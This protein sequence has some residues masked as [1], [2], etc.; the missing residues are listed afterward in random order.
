MKDK[1]KIVGS[2]G[3]CSVL[4]FAFALITFGN[5]NPGFDFMNDYI[6]KLGAKGEPNAL[7]FNIIG[8]ITVGLLLSTFGLSYG[9]ILKDKILSIL[10]ALFGLG[11]AFTAIPANLEMS[12][13]SVSKSHTV[14][15]CLGL[16]CWL[17]S[18]S[19]L[20]SNQKL[21]FSIRNRANITAVLIVISMIGFVLGFWTIPIT[22]RLVFGIVFGWTAI[23]SVG[24]LI[25]E[26]IQK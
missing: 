1:N 9:K 4:L 21:K 20:G 26:K 2:I 14:A 23:S 7:R 25:N 11:F 22:H 6:S 3:L 18:L 19:R 15:I 8:F 16:A 10:L 17:F 12:T 24:L 13:T 5:L